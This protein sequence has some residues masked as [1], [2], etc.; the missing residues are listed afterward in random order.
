[1]KNIISLLCCLSLFSLCIN[2]STVSATDYDVFEG[3]LQNAIISE[4]GT[5]EHPCKLSICI[6]KN[7]K[8]ERLLNYIH[9]VLILALAII[10]FIF[11]ESILL[12]HG[13]IIL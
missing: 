2:F 1:M 3:E 6:N 4:N 9:F 7:S 11:N 12:V 10:T 13:Y 8:T 5:S